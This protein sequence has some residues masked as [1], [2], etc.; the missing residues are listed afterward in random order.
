ME[1][2]ITKIEHKMADP[3][4][5]QDGEKELE[6]A[7]ERNDAGT[8]V[9]PEEVKD[10]KEDSVSELDS[11]DLADKNTGKHARKRSVLKRDDRPRLPGALEKRV[12]FSSAPSDRRVSNGMSDIIH[13]LI[14][15][16]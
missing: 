8:D 15:F 12:S 6:I 11:V 3:G 1:S 9:K 4:S 10:S 16:H 7:V 13:S 2:L 14:C 5:T